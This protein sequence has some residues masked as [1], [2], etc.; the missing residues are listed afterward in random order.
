MIIAIKDGEKALLAY[1]NTYDTVNLSAQDFYD[2]ENIPFKICK[3][4]GMVCGFCE[5]TRLSDKL[6]YD[7]E[8]LAGEITP[9]AF[10]RDIIPYIKEKA[11]E[12]N[13]ISK[14]KWENDFIVCKGNKIYGVDGDFVL[15]EGTDF[16]MFGIGRDAVKGVLDATKGLP[17]RERIAKAIDFYGETTRSNYYPI[18]I[19]DTEKFALEFLEKGDVK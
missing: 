15:R 8:F 1:V 12:E 4:K 2:E 16:L 11:G 19:V 10:R 3:E 5:F 6:L 18:A 7:D 14:G 9:Q 17:A 13:F